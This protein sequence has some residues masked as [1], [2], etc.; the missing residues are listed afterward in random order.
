MSFFFWLLATG[1]HKGTPRDRSKSLFIA[2]LEAL[3]Q[4]VVSQVLLN[5]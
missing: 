2:A 4:P 1:N 3:S 5:G